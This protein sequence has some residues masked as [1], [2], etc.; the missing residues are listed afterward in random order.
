MSSTTW[1]GAPDIMD[2]SVILPVYNE[3][4]RLAASVGKVEEYLAEKYSPFE[5]IIVEDNS[6][7]DS[8]TVA[9]RL[10]NK[11]KNVVLLHNESRIG[12]GASV[13]AALKKARG[14]Y[15]AYMDVDLATDLGYVGLLVAGLDKGAVVSTGSRYMSGAHVKRPLERSIASRSYNGMVRLLFNSK[16]L[17]HQCGFKGFNRKKTEKVLGL[18]RDNHWFWDTEL[19]IICQA[20][21]MKIFEFPVTWEHNGGNALNPS[22]VKVL[23]DSVTMGRKVLELKRRLSTGKLANIAISP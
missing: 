20:L 2:L 1:T 15:A 18:V 12:R 14:D 6:T 19:L 9:R 21:G 13:S 22:K 8:Y 16:I 5:V 17:D 3:G 10:A 11:D 23:K 4:N 7:D